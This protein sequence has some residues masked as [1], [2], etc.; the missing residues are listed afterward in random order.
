MPSCQGLMFICGDRWSCR[1]PVFQIR[2]C[3]R[4]MNWCYQKMISQKCFPQFTNAWHFTIRPLWVFCFS[5]LFVCLLR[6]RWKSFLLLSNK[7]ESLALAYDVSIIQSLSIS[8]T[9]SSISLTF[10]Y[11]FIVIKY[12]V[13]TQIFETTS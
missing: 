13:Q 6:F 8:S 1:K 12:D 10:F 4:V 11:M 3:L 7:V 5:F 9:S 2:D